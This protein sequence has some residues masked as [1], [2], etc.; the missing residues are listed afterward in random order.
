MNYIIVTGGA[1]FI[2]SNLI[3]SLIK[4]KNSKIISIDNYFT[5]NKKNHVKHKNVSYIKGDTKNFSKIFNHLIGKIKVIFHF[6]EFSRIAQS[7]DNDKY[8]RCFQSNMHGSYE[9]IN[10][11][12]VN[13][14]K[15]IYSATSA[16]LGNKGIDQNL[17]PYAF[18]K[19]NNM[20]LIMN[21]NEWFGLK[22][23]IIYFYNVYG[24]NQ[25]YNS[26]MAAVVGIFENYYRKNKALPIVRPG[27]QSRK[28]THVKDTVE[29]CIYAWKKNKNL[30]YSISN[31]KS[32][33]ILQLAN[34]FSKKIK[35]IPERRGE[36]F[37]SSIVHK[38]RNKKIINLIGKESL[39]KYV[40]DLKE[41]L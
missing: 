27:T 3:K 20:N 35:M 39:Q 26:S 34:L 22:Y 32:Y 36:R 33:S 41:R 5:G 28:F 7:F 2:G 15:I 23:E 14:I 21:L 30:H 18:T 11:C 25:I 1:G 31:N 17:S 8:D 29:A 10:F 13:K 19:S 24:P 9:V 38:V 4:D 6:A 40:K 12:L 16:S 37:V